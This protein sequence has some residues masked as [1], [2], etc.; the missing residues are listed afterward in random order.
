LEVLGDTNIDG[1]LHVED[2]IYV[3]NLGDDIY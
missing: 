2:L 1:D 3:K